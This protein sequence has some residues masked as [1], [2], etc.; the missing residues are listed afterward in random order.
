MRATLESLL[1]IRLTS[2][3]CLSGFIAVTPIQRSAVRLSRAN[4]RLNSNQLAARVRAS[5]YLAGIVFQMCFANAKQG[6]T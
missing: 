5:S 3:Q 4:R 2:R 6:Y 1:E